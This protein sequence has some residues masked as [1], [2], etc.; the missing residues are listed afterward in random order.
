MLRFSFTEKRI[1]NLKKII[2][3]LWMMV[4]MAGVALAEARFPAPEFD[5][6]HK[7]PS[8]TAPL[9][10]GDYSGY[11]DL[12]LLVIA[13]AL[14]SWLLLRKRSRKGIFALSLFS[15]I[16]FGFIRHGC[17]CVVGSLQNVTMALFDSSYTIPIVLVAF[18]ML[19]LIFALFFGRVF[20]GAVCPLGMIQD[21]VAFKPIKV[22]PWL[23]NILG[24]I[25]YFYLGL[26]VLFAATG[27]GFIICQYDPFVAFFRL[28]GS[29]NMLL[30]GAAFLLVG[31][32]VA[33][34]YCRYLCPYGVLLRWTAFF[35]KYNVSITPTDCIQCRLCEDACPYGSIRKPS[36]ERLPEAREVGVRRL[37]KLLVLF[38]LIVIAGGVAGFLIY[39]PLSTAHPV[40]SLAEQVALEDSGVTTVM[41]LASEAFRETG[42]SVADLYT[43]ALMVRNKFKLG[44]VLLGIWL[45]I[46]IG[47]KLLS[48]SV[49][50]SRKD[51]EPDRATCLSCGRC[52]ESCPVGEKKEIEKVSVG[53]CEC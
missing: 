43:E 46:V 3:M 19:P 48:L 11:L 10:G 45:G 30:L 15:L 20:C 26:A 36:P 17:I 25:P 23:E 50:R 6:G 37:R 29:F 40:V 41:T 49:Y 18:F 8:P 34:P 1:H 27:A 7:I 4:V 31:I 51:Y 22:S 42:Q 44:S 9:P 5:T 12:S 2:I 28:G 13:M 16:Y 14:A 47:G 52:Y 38:P 32:F 35:S 24:L 53:V 39:I 33:R 21:V